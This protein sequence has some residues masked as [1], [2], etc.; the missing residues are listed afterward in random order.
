ME[1]NKIRQDKKSWMKFTVSL[2]ELRPMLHTI[3]LLTTAIYIIVFFLNQDWA[4]Q[5]VDAYPLAAYILASIPDVA[6]AFYFEKIVSNVIDSCG[7]AIARFRQAK[8]IAV[9]VSGVTVVLVFFAAA[10]SSFGVTSTIRTD[11]GERVD[12]MLSL[13]DKLI[14]GVVNVK[15]TKAADTYMELRSQGRALLL[16]EKKTKIEQVNKRYPDTTS[17]WHNNNRSRALASIEAT[18]NEKILKFDEQTDKEYKERTER[19]DDFQE[20]VAESN[21]ELMNTVLVSYQSEDNRLD[22]LSGLMSYGVIIAV[23]LSLISSITSHQVCYV[24]GMEMDELIMEYRQNQLAALA[25]K[26]KLKGKK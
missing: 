14:A 17:A 5:F 3:S 2:M 7:F 11:K 15:D 18:Y 13:N 6:A 9:M 1:Q 8:R 22:W 10:S 19:S 12:E 21:K 23:L 4:I 25:A 26:N 20:E 16:D 24:L